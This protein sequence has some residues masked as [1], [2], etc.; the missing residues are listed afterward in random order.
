MG[1]AKDQICVEC[2]KPGSLRTHPECKRTRE[3]RLER[4]RRRRQREETGVTSSE[5]TR[6][7][8]A[9]RLGL[10]TETLVHLMGQPCDVCQSDAPETRKN[11]SAYARKDT[12][13]VTGTI[14]QKCAT[15][16]GFFQHDPE[17]LRA[18][19]DLL[20]ADTDLRDRT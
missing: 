3:A 13:A 8:H 1:M 18:A 9:K 4:D 2:N 11:N 15:A 7:Y 20:T 10:R 19:L 5:M 12:G 16:L 17:R 6:N 14:C